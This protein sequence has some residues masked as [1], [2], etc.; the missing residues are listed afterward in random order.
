M[1]SLRSIATIA[2]ATL[3]LFCAG[4][5][6][7][8]PDATRLGSSTPLAAMHKDK[9]VTCKG[10]HEEKNQ[11]KIVVDDNETVVNATCVVCH[12][13]LAEMAKE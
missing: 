1:K 2:I 11:E 13:T 5:S 4:A 8:A 10:C 6:Y 12:V 7:A 9:K 3:G